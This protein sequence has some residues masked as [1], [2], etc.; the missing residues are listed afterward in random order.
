MVSVPEPPMPPPESVST[1]TV[2]VSLTF[3][4][5]VAICTELLEP[6]TVGLEDQF[7]ALDQ[8]A[9]PAQMATCA[10]ANPIVSAT[11]ATMAA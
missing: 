2:R 10:R 5:P 8:S 4:V 3:A 1:L 11:R 6:G 7:A 9:D